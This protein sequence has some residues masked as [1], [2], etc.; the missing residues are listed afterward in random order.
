MQYSIKKN[1]NHFASK[2]FHIFLM[3]NKT[4][5]LNKKSKAVRETGKILPVPIRIVQLAAQLIYVVLWDCAIFPSLQ[6]CV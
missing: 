1:L 6:C 3:E 4:K 5:I 2:K